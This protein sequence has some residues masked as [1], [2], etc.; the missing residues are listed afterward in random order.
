M[1]AKEF[2]TRTITAF[3][4]IAA[5]YALIKFTPDRWFS[6]VL[7][8]LISAGAY[9][10]VKL[11]QPTKY[12]LIFVL[13]TGLIVGY[14]F[15]FRKTDSQPDLLPGIILILV[16]TGL[17][18]LFSIRRKEDL[19]TFVKDMGIHFL[20]IFYLYVP[21]YFILEL[22]R[23]GPN[24]LFFMI[25]VIA[26]GDSGAYFVGSAIGKHKIYPIASPK[27][28]LEGLIAAVITAALS[29]WL[30]ILVFSLPVKVWLAVVTGG[31]IG[32]LSQ[33]SDPIESL[34]KRAAGK[35]DSGTILP[36]HGGVLDRLDSY[37]FCAPVL[38]YIILYF[39]K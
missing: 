23:L 5:A 27:K 18:F 31:V 38:F 24:F 20:I 7:F 28:T 30:S 15:T 14:L 13:L 21:L 1:N 3:F 36:G 34:F 39:W 35:K 2:L 17:F 19:D 12:S 22:K 6:L 32:L 25:F 37:I 4:L 29:G 26:V 8:L 16:L 11:T 9:E 33:L 10:L